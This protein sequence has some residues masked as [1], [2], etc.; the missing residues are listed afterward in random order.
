MTGTGTDMNGHGQLLIIS[1]PSGSGKERL[2]EIVQANSRRSQGPFIR[3]NVGAIPEELMES[4]L[5]GA[6]VGAYTG[7]EKRRIGHF[8]TTV[9]HDGALK[10][11][12]GL[13]P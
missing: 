3:V 1:G 4:E 5:F 11:G 9:E 10:V 13:S 2:A 6:E 8:E 12:S 7:L